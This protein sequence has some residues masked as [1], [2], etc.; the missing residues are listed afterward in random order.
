MFLGGGVEVCYLTFG[1]AFFLTLFPQ[2]ILGLI[3]FI[4]LRRRLEIFGVFCVVFFG[5]SAI[6]L[7]PFHELSQLSIR[8]HGISY[9]K[10]SIWSLHPLDLLEIFV[11]DQYGLAT[12]W[13][14]YWSHQHWLKTIYMGG[15]PFLLSFFFIKKFDRQALGFL[16]LFFISLGLATGH[17]S[18][19]HYILYEYLPFFDKFRYPVKFIFIGILVISI[20]AGIGYDCLKKD[21]STNSNLK[22]S[23]MVWVLFI[24]FLFMV[25]FGVLD[26]YNKE[27]TE[28]FNKIGWA[29]PNYN[30][31]NINLFNIK[32]FLVF[33]SLCCLLL[34]LYPK[35]KFR[36]KFVLGLMIGLLTL[37]LFF[38]HY[39]FFVRQGLDRFNKRAESAEFI[40]SDKSNARTYVPSETYHKPFKNVIK[41]S[42][43]M[44]LKK[45]R[46]TTG[47]LGNLPIHFASGIAVTAQ[48]KWSQLNS[49]VETSPELNSTDIL[50]LMNVKYYVSIEPVKDKGFTL[51][52]SGTPSSGKEVELKQFEESNAIR[53]Y[54]NKNVLPRSFLVPNCKVIDSGK[55]FK[56]TFAKKLF[57]PKTVVLLEKQPAG[58]DCKK[59]KSDFSEKGKVE[60]S[61]YKS[62]TVKLTVNSKIRQFLL[63]N[64]S[65]YPGWKAYIDGEETE[66]LNANYLFRAIVIGPGEHQVRFKYEPLSFKLGLAISVTT[67]ILCGTYLYRS[68]NRRKMQESIG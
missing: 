49:L 16:L 31:V 23:P 56:N 15:I 47:I 9:D 62:N 61:S 43:N 45:E 5:L 4:K 65:Y 57:D 18:Y 10:A 11:P 48:K 44:N 8:S 37:D 38:A 52:Y 54:E 27:F 50:N 1:L 29:P 60:I 58:L 7:L 34:Y 40:L 20:T 28:Y 21:I 30:E 35:P 6:Q 67:L 17:H 55:E 3:E 2:L 25:V 14:N 53:V 63:L 19:L 59:S 26:F 46:F 42:E 41:T 66:V 64:D 36:N 13:Q 32:R 24:G 33:T 22:T 39:K 68:R 12:D 51:V